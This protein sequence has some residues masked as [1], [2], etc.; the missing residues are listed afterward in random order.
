MVA[1]NLA[2][3]GAGSACVGKGANQKEK[4]LGNCPCQL[5]R[6]QNQSQ[7]SPIPH[8]CANAMPI[9]PTAEL[10]I[11]SLPPEIKGQPVRCRIN[12]GPHNKGSSRA[13]CSTWNLAIS[14]TGFP[15][16]HGSGNWNPQFSL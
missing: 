10:L 1:K 3:S 9:R 15:I 5:P 11:S 2:F 14:G 7:E 8:Y 16:G 13:L 12:S 6:R 4:T